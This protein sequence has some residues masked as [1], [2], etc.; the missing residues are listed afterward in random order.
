MRSLWL[1]LCVFQFLLLVGFLSSDQTNPSNHERSTKARQNPITV[2]EA[3]ARFTAMPLSAVRKESLVVSRFA[4]TDRSLL[5][6]TDPNLIRV[7]IKLDYDSVS[8]YAGGIK[9]LA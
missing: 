9:T 2:Q 8:I 3:L 1:S 5:N 7:M 4:K 6:R